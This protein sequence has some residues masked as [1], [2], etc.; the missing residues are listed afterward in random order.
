MALRTIFR[1]KSA[2][3]C[4]ILPIV[5]P[6]SHR[7]GPGVWIRTPI[8]ACLASFPI[9]P[10]LQ[11]DNCWT[12]IQVHIIQIACN[13]IQRILVLIY[14]DFVPISRFIIFYLTILPL[15]AVYTLHIAL[16]SA[17]VPRSRYTVSLSLFLDWLIDWIVSICSVCDSAAMIAK[18]PKRVARIWKQNARKVLVHTARAI[19]AG[20]GVVAAATVVVTAIYQLLN[21]SGRGVNGHFSAPY[22]QQAGTGIQGI[23]MMSGSTDWADMIVDSVD[24]SECM[25]IDE[26]RRYE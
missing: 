7:S 20:V 6:D 25:C 4:R 18:S 14:P 26:C 16:F 24:N 9:V 17:C 23:L 1:P 15:R 10:V 19:I 13:R 12:C 3:D 11:N 2:L 8:S 5:S 22:K 21:S